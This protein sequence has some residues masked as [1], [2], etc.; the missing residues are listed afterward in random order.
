MLN[1]Y[2]MRPGNKVLVKAGFIDREAARTFITAELGAVIEFEDQD[3]IYADAV[4]ITTRDCRQYSIE[5]TV[6]DRF[7]QRYAELMAEAVA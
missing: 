5:M 6:L 1:V 4:D 7:N 2:E 3:P